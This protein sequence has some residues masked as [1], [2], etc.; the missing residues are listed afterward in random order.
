VLE[1]RME[2]SGV[3]LMAWGGGAAVLLWRVRRRGLALRA[4][5]AAAEWRAVRGV[6]AGSGQDAMRNPAVRDRVLELVATARAARGV[7][8]GDKVLV[9]YLGTATYDL[10]EARERQTVRFVEAGCVVQ[11]LD[12]ARARPEPSRCEALLG[13]ADAVVVSGGNTLFAMDRWTALGIAPL[14][15]AAAAR[16]AVLAG[17][18]AG[19]IAPFEGGHSDSMDPAT[20]ASAMLDGVPADTQAGRAWRYIRVPALGILP[21]LV[22]PHH[23]K[24]QSN[25]VPR[26]SDLDAML[27]RH[28]GERALCIDHDAVLVLPGDGSFEVLA[29]KPGASV[30]LKSVLDGVVVREP[31]AAR[32]DASVFLRRAASIAEDPLVHQCRLDNP[33]GERAKPA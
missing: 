16:G 12:C 11:A 30:C 27:L 19:A 9:V 33:S 17:G 28:A 24:V 26:A 21:G 7:P 1:R 31:L 10:A 18:S 32:G 14:L 29:L 8:Q 5:G 23:D 6:F 15:R 13:A 2:R 25:G 3:A 4:A 22:C 20:Y